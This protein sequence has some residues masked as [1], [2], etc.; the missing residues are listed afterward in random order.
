V[1]HRGRRQR[2]FGNRASQRF[3]KAEVIELDTPGRS[4]H[5]LGDNGSKRRH[6]L[7]AAV[8]QLEVDAFE[9]IDEIAM[10]ALAAEL[11]VRNALKAQR[12]L[13]G[14]GFTDAFVL[15]DAKR[16]LADVAGR[17]LCPQRKQAGRSQQT[18]D[19]IG[20]KR[21]PLFAHSAYSAA[22]AAVAA[23]ASVSG[24]WISFMRNDSLVAMP[25]TRA[26]NR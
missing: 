2:L 17:A 22:S 14:N 18:A 12:L 11:A 25:S 10:K 1:R 8:E 19:V 5:A 7:G 9:P 4:L 15:A 23:G 20:P 3:Q 26:E 13:H 16:S 24:G 6:A 21:G